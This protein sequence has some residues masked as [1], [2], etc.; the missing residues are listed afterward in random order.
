MVNGFV[1]NDL[2]CGFQSG[3]FSYDMQEGGLLSLEC[4]WSELEG[5]YSVTDGAGNHRMSNFQWN[6]NTFPFRSPPFLIAALPRAD[7]CIDDLFFAF[8]ESVEQT[9]SSAVFTTSLN[10]NAVSMSTSAELTTILGQTNTN[11]NTNATETQV[12]TMPSTFE[13]SENELSL[14]MSV[15]STFD[16]MIESPT[17]TTNDGISSTTWTIVAVCAVVFVL[18]VLGCGFLFAFCSSRT[19]T[20][21]NNHANANVYD[22][23]LPDSRERLESQSQRASHAGAIEYGRV[24]IVNRDE[25]YDTGSV[26][27]FANRESGYGGVNDVLGDYGSG[28]VEL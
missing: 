10:V 14:S 5:F 18:L 19:P 13:T 26:E 12:V 28:D 9:T 11:T 17:A 8:N 15:S 7:Y 21:S 24:D 6:A 1:E 22:N 27:H 25:D 2:I 4:T 20:E 3:S 23:G 16:A